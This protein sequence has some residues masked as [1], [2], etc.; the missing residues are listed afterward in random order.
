MKTLLFALVLALT[1]PSLE[2]W[3]DPGIFQKN[4]LPMAATFTTDQQLSQSLDGLW[5]FGFYDTPLLLSLIHI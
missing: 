3:Q 4:R 2:D 1:A 5:K